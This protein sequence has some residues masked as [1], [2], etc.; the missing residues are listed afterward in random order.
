MIN[1]QQL[2]ETVEHRV[3]ELVRQRVR[4]AFKLSDANAQR[5]NGSNGPV[6]DNSVPADAYAVVSPHD[7][8]FDDDSPADIEDFE[9]PLSIDLHL[10]TVPAGSDLTDIAERAIGLLHQA[11]LQDPKWTDPATQAELAT[12]TVVKGR[13][14][15]TA[16]PGQDDPTC[17]VDVVI[18]TRH[19]FGEPF[20]P[21]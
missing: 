18:T 15:P 3:I 7:S 20:T 2:P 9:L 14:R 17:G 16:H 19:A 6:A 21:A 13:F 1:L 12:D 4:D 5:F 8:D 11:L 10:V